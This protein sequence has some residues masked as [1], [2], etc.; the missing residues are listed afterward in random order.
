MAPHRKIQFD[1]H[2]SYAFHLPTWHI[3]WLPA[4]WARRVSVSRGS[5]FLA[6]EFI[7]PVV[8]NIFRPLFFTNIAFQAV[9]SKP[10]AEAI[11]FSRSHVFLFS[12]R[13]LARGVSIFL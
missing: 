6:F 8:S 2:T 10:Q 12:H 11:V 9:P 1:H 13:F 4:T 7:R 5:F 3:S